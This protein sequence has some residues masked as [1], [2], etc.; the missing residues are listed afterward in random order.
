M[1][2]EMIFDIIGGLGIFLLGMKSMSEGMQAVAGSKL[3]SMINAVTNNRLLACSVGVG[4]TCLVQSSSITTVMVV[5]MVNAGLMTLI[6]AIG[7]ILGANIGTTI[8]GWILISKVGGF[9]LPIIAVSSV[10]YL[11]SKKDF[12]RFT[13]SI[14]L[15]LGL[16]FF[17]MQLMKQGFAPLEHADGFKEWF[18]RFEPTTYLGVLKCCLVGAIM[19]AIL[20]SCRLRW[21]LLL[22]LY[23]Q[24]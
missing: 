3:R 2:S 11:F 23:L 14:F 16:V 10:F 12:I 20:Q 15:G 5:G 1:T 17:G 8:T 19:T 6:Q 18:T 7:V 22:V 4:M 21:E 13:A 9:G 24:E